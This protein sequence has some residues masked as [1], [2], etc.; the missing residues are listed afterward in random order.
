[1][2]STGPVILIVEDE[3]LI[4]LD[5]ANEVQALG[6]SVWDQSQEWNQL[7]RFLIIILRKPRC[8]MPI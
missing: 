6:H 2:K 5:L 1:M 4:A 8:W 3:G 7:R